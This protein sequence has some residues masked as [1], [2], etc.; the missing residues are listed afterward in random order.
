MRRVF[1]KKAWGLLGM[2]LVF[3]FRAGAYELKFSS[4]MS[5][6]QVELLGQDQL[7]ISQLKSSSQSTPQNSSQLN[8]N[9]N[10]GVSGSNVA[11]ATFYRS[12]LA[13]LYRLNFNDDKNWNDWI[14]ARAKIILNAE[15]ELSEN[16]IVS[17]DF[18]YSN[19]ILPISNDGFLPPSLMQEVQSR[20]KAI[21]MLNV[22][23]AIYSSGKATGD[24]KGLQVDG[25]GLIPIN[26]PRVGII[27]AGDLFFDPVKLGTSNVASRLV[28]SLFRL[29]TL[30][31]EARHSDGREQSL[32]FAHAACPKGHPYAGYRACDTAVNGPYYLGSLVL[33]L[34]ARSCTDCT[35]GDRDALKILANDVELRVLS[36]FYRL[37]SSASSGS[38]SGD[39]AVRKLCQMSG[40][41]LDC[42]NNNREG[43]GEVLWD[44]Q[45]ETA[46]WGVAP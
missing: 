42:S 18:N 20:S 5:T 22:G 16:T 30:W 32:S 24:R 35:A 6:Q 3:Q 8:P 43:V 29:S 10:S 23:A 17:L 44:D 46:S 14:N 26:S 2:I 34:A 27:Q 38:S 33:N 9:S 40:L 13:Q 41:K 45:P 37:S 31:H 36:P 25:Q 12:R 11:E 1:G 7:L 15:H 28:G 21:L 39:S 19:K 4:G